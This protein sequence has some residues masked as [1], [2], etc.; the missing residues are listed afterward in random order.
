VPV[1]VL[2]FFMFLSAVFVS[3][4]EI[5]WKAWDGRLGV[6]V[7]NLRTVRV[8]YRVYASESSGAGSHELSRINLNY[9]L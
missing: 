8:V 2:G 6:F 3:T 1:P 4:V 9:Q 5:D 7:R